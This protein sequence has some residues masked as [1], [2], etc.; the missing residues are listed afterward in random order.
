MANRLQ[1]QIITQYLPA[2]PYRPAVPARCVQIKKTL[3]GGTIV[4][5][6]RA[7]VD[8]NGKVRYL[9]VYTQVPERIFYETVCYPAQPEVKGRAASTTYTPI[10]GW[11]AGARS[12]E[13]LDGDGY[14]EFSVNRG[15]LGA[16]V[17]FS[18]ADNTPLPSEQSHAF[19]IHGSTVDIMEQ[20]QV[21]AAGVAAHAAG[22]VYRI[23][24]VGGVVTY[25]VGGWALDS[26]IQSVGQ[27]VL[28]ASLYASGDT[29]DNPTIAAITDVP[30]RGNGSFK[31]LEGVGAEGAYAFG[32]GSFAPL[33]GY[34]VG[35][36]I[37]RGAGSFQAMQ[38]AGA[39][40]AYSAGSGSFAALTG[41]GVSGYPEISFSS[42]MGVF[43]PMS[44]VGIG[45]TGEVGYGFG[46]F[47]TPSG[48]GAD[49]VY[50]QGSGSFL[51][52]TGQGD[53]SRY[54]EYES[55]FSSPLALLGTFEPDRVDFS[56]FS[57]GLALGGYFE[58][59]MLA[60]DYFQST[61]MLGSLWSSDYALEGSFS[62]AL[63]IGGSVTGLVMAEGMAGRLAAEPAQYAVNVQTGALAQYVGFAFIGF[64]Q[65]EQALYACRPDGVYMIRSG[66]DDGLP[67]QALI[68]FGA[69]DY[70]TS[71]V[72]RLESAYFG[73]ET[74][75][76]VTMRLDTDSGEQAYRV[77]RHG[78]M[79]RVVTAKGASGRLWNMTLEIED[80]THFELDAIEAQVGATTRRLGRR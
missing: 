25:S 3:P 11:N 61:L 48:M 54:G 72:K 40:Y 74:D 76:S 31:P 49:R 66:D 71:Q 57:S 79:A 39:N 18:Y 6:W 42:G 22:N 41:E 77:A 51:P 59:T 26:A 12:I 56:S 64:A 47:G 70:G 55:Y 14:V 5:T 43:T 21:V 50:A 67:L 17:G 28:D 20:G 36:A 29:V 60:S 7:V 15:V 35:A 4:T 1:K 75:A 73:M 13:A 37:S 58:L 65:A 53:V 45:L 9:P 33:E 34:G 10:T 27:V 23:S 63:R 46:E 24:R 68:D 30:G 62:S 78:T 80:A 44:G 16:V 19:Y 69:T 52:L 38:G 8:R 32:L 2:I